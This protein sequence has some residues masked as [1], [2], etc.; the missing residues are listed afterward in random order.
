MTQVRL[1]DIKGAI[2]DIDDTLLDNQHPDVGPLHERSRFEAVMRIADKYQIESLRTLTHDENMTAFHNAKTHSLP[3]AVWGILYQ[4]GIVDTEDI[5]LAHVLLN[6]LV[7]LKNELHADVLRQHGRAVLGAMELV[8]QM[9]QQHGIADTMAIASS[10]YRRDIDIFVDE[11]YPDLRAL[12][13]ANRIV[14]YE[15]IPHKQG[16]PHPEPFNRAFQTL[17]LPSEARGNVLAFEDDPRGIRS[18]KG[19]GLY[20]CAITTRFSRDHPDLIAAKPDIII[21]SYEDFARQ[22]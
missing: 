18:A 15:D 8:H 4:K 2:F 16:K 7:D 20:V 11:L 22:L 19:A 6:E 1:P 5:D 9:A 14:A 17:N 13:P 3:G 21:D 12:F 10:A